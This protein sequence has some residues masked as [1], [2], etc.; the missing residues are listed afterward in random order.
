MARLERLGIGGG[1]VMSLQTVRAVYKSGTLIFIDPALAPRD[2]TE[3]VVTFVE[4]FQTEPSSRV[5]PIQALR[6]RGKGEKLVEKLLQ[7]RREDQE[8]DEQNHR[9]LRV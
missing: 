7:S 3:V 1:D 2:G 9:R 8:Q 6:G 5:D 4:K